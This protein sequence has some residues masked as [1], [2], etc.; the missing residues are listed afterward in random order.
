M[1]S[2]LELA[3]AVTAYI[4]PYLPSLLKAGKFV[5]EKAAEETIK[6]RAGELWSSIKAHFTEQTGLQDAARLVAS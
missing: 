4:A 3:A 6:M 1:M 2:V 5:G